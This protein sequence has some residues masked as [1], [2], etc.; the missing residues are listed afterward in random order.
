MNINPVSFG[1]RLPLTTCY[2]QNQYN[3]TL[4]PATFCELDPNDPEDIRDIE[5]LSDYKFQFKDNIA[6]NMSH[7]NALNNIKNNIQ[8]NN[9]I[10]LMLEETAPA[11]YFL[12]EHPKG[13]II[14][15]TQISRQ[16]QNVNIDYISRNKMEPYTFIGQD[17]IA[18]IC[19]DILKS[20]D[21][22]KLIVEYPAASAK[23]FYTNVCGFKYDRR[24]ILAMNRKQMQK[25]VDSV[26]KKTQHPI[27][28]LSG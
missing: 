11:R 26:E 13:S 5:N 9:D 7:H 4:V 1:Q 12:M 28:N 22:K 25:F 10:N 14:G 16:G 23:K 27:L 17:M 8:N 6:Y 18:S 15:I 19:S 20:Y 24:G 2:V 3:G 21:V